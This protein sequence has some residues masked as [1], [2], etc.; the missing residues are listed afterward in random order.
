MSKNLITVLDTETTNLHAN[1]AEVVEVAAAHWD[2]SDWAVEGMLLGAINGIPPEASAKNN[3]SNRMI[4]NK[5]TF[6]HCAELVSQ[7]LKWDTTGY[8]VA[9]N[10][11]Y[12]R[13]VLSKAWTDAGFNDHA[14]VCN[15]DNRWL[16]TW[17]L[18][19]HLLHTEFTDI[20][21]GLNYLRY[22]L[23]L[24]VDDNMQLHRAKDD[25]YLCATLFDWLVEYSKQT[26]YIEPD[27]DEELVYK[28]LNLL[29]WSPMPITRWP[30]GKYRGTLL[31]DIPNDYYV[32]AM[33][34]I[35]A[36]KEDSAEY[37]WDLAE[38]VRQVLEVRLNSVD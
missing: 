32:W 20:E 25:T 27:A 23:D 31:T 16:C 5:P 19:R 36:L 33:L 11:R 15:N 17:R 18:S 8:F 7:L 35:P 13:A 30:F 12:D 14:S 10:A 21:Y 2:G 34:N 28:V 24:P 38:N 3:I 22:K 9:H 1:L 37:D 6:V 4:A 26:G 29:C